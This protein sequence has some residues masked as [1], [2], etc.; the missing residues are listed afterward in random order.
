MA[1]REAQNAWSTGKRAEAQA[2]V[3][4]AYRTWFEPLEP[5][6]R[7]EDPLA[8]LRLEFEFGALAQ[9]MGTQGDPVELNDAVMALVDG[10]DGL[11][12][13]LPA[14]PP[15]ALEGVKMA[16]EAL[17]VA[18]EVEAPKREFTTYGDA[19]D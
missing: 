15:G 13:K 4:S 6:L 7:H 19:K 9:R 14:P 16:S 2:R 5:V 18:V 12:Q 10:M 17:P 8:T 1:L 3:Q 11:V